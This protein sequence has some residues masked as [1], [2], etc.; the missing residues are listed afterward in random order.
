MNSVEE[1]YVGKYHKKRENTFR[2]MRIQQI[3]GE[4]KYFLD[5]LSKL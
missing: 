5:K 3:K 2:D 4:M 1:I